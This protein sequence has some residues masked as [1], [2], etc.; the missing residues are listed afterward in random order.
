MKNQVIVVKLIYQRIDNQTMGQTHLILFV[1]KILNLLF[2]IQS[3][4]IK[5]RTL[6]LPFIIFC[7][8]SL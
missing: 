3:T 8:D 1:I 7:N 4:F 6:F 2:K 5:P